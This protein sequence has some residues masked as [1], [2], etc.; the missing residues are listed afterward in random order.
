M[1]IPEFTLPDWLEGCD[2]DTIQKRMMDR[3]PQD[4]D[5]TEGGF[6]W[7]FTAPTA[8][9][10]AEL[11]QFYVPETLKAM[12]HMWAYGKW[13]DYH[14]VAV[15]LER[16][17]AG[18]ASGTVRVAGAG[19]TV[20]PEGF[21]FAVPTDGTAP[22]VEFSAADTC[23]IGGDGYVDVEVV[24]VVPGASGNVAAGTV[25]VMSEPISGIVDISNPER[26]TGGTMEEPD[27]SLRERIG[28][29]YQNSV[30]YL[31][32]DADYV[33]W[34]KQA[35]AGDCIV[36]PAA[37]GPGTVKLVLVD[38]NGQPANE[39]LVQDVYDYIVSPDDRSARLLPTACSRLICGP[40]TT[41]KVSF[42]VTGI[43][44]DGTTDIGQVKSDFAA[45]LRPV[46]TAAKQGG[47]LR[48]NDVRPILSDI[49][50]VTDFKD[51]LMDGRMENIELDSEEYPETGDLDFS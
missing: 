19:G 15:G 30:T 27:D 48:Y 35:G 43:L 13:L 8:L 39:R 40:A 45:A 17:A 5:R 14:A 7:D 41:V 22:A 49:A 24:A 23:A 26:M 42:T 44:H 20:I 2:F 37:E 33:R 16:K 28:A 4:I 51:F 1:A 3:L 9:E 11:L 29:E 25:T 12:Y 32:N 31:G 46:Y 47:I 34:S 18:P 50:G 21:R 36:V 38:A 6:P 10:I